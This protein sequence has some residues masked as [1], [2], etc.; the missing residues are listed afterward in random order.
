MTADDDQN[1][2]SEV[3]VKKISLKKINPQTDVK[4][5]DDKKKDS[6]N[7]TS[8]SD[9]QPKNADPPV[10]LPDS[11]TRLDKM[12]KK[13]DWLSKNPAFNGGVSKVKFLENMLKEFKEAEQVIN[14][15]LETEKKVENSDDKKEESPSDKTEFKYSANNGKISNMD[16]H[17]SSDPEPK[18]K[19]QGKADLAEMELKLNSLKKEHEE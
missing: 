4:K 12:I 16:V 13:P 18:E 5:V 14:D 8:S 15:K 7:D 1:S 19:V 6:K 11:V 17:K 2:S 3:S 9:P 10:D